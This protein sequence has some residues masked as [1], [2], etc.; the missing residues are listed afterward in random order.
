MD[1]LEGTTTDDAEWVTTSTAA[2]LNRWEGGVLYYSNTTMTLADWEADREHEDAM[3][4]AQERI[5]AEWFNEHHR[6]PWP[7][8]SAGGIES[9]VARTL[10]KLGVKGIR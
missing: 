2:P 6:A 5:K 9:M 10:I 8:S 4:R 1:I 3:I 7:N